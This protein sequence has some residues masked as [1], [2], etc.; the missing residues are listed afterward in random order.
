MPDAPAQKLRE[1]AAANGRSLQ[2]ELL[3]LLESAT[4]DRREPPRVIPPR[5]SDLPR[6]TV[7]ELLEVSRAMFPN[8]TPSSVAF[9]RAQR[10]AGLSVDLG[11]WPDPDPSK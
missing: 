11:P 3:A 7:R 8:G 10:D 5:G 1:R 4:G 6:M 2:R 9:I